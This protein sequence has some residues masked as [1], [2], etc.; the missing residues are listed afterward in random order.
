MLQKIG[1]EKNHVLL[2]LIPWAAGIISVPFISFL[3]SVVI[4]VVGVVL[5]V[6]CWIKKGVV[7]AGKVLWAC[8]VIF[9]AY[10]IA[11][12]IAELL[13]AGWNALT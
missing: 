5:L 1:L 7:Y 4:L 3:A 8:V 9:I 10:Y 13:D 2:A 12:G 6:V 11:I